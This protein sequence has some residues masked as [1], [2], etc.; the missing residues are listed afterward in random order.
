[1]QE[2]RQKT[3]VLVYDGECG[4]CREW[5]QYW[6][7]LTGGNVIYRPYQEVAANYPDISID[8][9]KRA[10]QLIEPDGTVI[11]GAD[12]TFRLY[13]NIPPY[14]LLRFL[15]RFLPGFAFLSEY[16]YGFFSRHRGLLSFITHLFW[17]KNFEP[18]RY[19]ITTWIFMRLLGC[20]YLSAFISFG[21]QALGLVG[22]EGLLPL[23][24]YLDYLSNQYGQNAWQYAPMI[25]WFYF[26]D[27]FLQ[28][29][30]LFGV[31]CALFIIFDF[32]TTV[33]L[34]LAYLLYLSLVYAGQTFMTFQ[35]DL[36]LLEAGFLAIFLGNRSNLMIWLYRWLVFRFVFLGGLVKILSGDPSWDSL[37]ALN[38]HFETQPLPTLIAWYAHHLPEWFLMTSTA[39][40]LIIELIIPFLIFTPRRFRILSA[41]TF[42]IFQTLIILTGNYNFFNLL[43][44]IMCL[45]LMDDAHVKRFLP[46][47]LIS[48]LS[49]RKIRM[50]GKLK[51]AF[52]ILFTVLILLASSEQ[53]VSMIK[54]NK[55]FE[56]SAL[57][58]V[59]Y[60]FHIVNSYGPFAVMTTVRREIVIEGTND[61]QTWREYEFK[62]K[63]GDV[64]RRPGFNIP[65]QPRLDWQM[66]FAALST[67][68]RNPWF[69]NLLIRL[70]QGNQSVEDLLL[71]NP[72]PYAPPMGIRAQFY[73]YR[74][75][76]PE[77]KRESGNWWKRKLIGEYFQ[78]IKLTP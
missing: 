61:G 75:T 36:L 49:S 18:P 60:P 30:C 31:I 7:K 5:V 70:L 6:E 1:M 26:S 43:P 41:W 39:A 57:N 45:F 69:R 21:I 59:M 28:F 40:T 50:A 46:Q 34:V 20:I 24:N 72:F 29:V 38:Y 78:P 44:I 53:L 14:S 65:H 56:W 47:F 2:N 55:Q 66:W 51:Q 35:W 16:F 8:E 37:T 67:A 9:F 71:V 76:T 15:Y 62:Y 48:R 3:G 54:K 10:I 58:R 13:K 4:I 32:F 73:E 74:F 23:N 42:I 17:G 12:A 52:L 64:A 22:S 19:E 77:E 25:F 68:E 11:N 33:S 27:A 63:P